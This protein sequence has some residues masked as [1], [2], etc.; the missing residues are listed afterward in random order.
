MQIVIDMQ[1]YH[2]LHAMRLLL[3][4]M[5]KKLI[6]VLWAERVVSLAQRCRQEAENWWP[7]FF[8]MAFTFFTLFDLHQPSVEPVLMLFSILYEKDRN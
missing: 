4:Y 3:S 7:A 2:L 8:A 5:R 1:Y 6:K